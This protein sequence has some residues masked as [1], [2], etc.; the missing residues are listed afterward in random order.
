MNIAADTQRFLPQQTAAARRIFFGLEK[1]FVVFSIIYFTNG[2]IVR[3][4]L[5]AELGAVLGNL[6]LLIYFG[7]IVLF[8]VHQ[9]GKRLTLTV[10][11]GVLPFVVYIFASVMWSI[12]A[13]HSL[14]EAIAFLGITMFALYLTVRFRFETILNLLTISFALLAVGSLILGAVAPSLGI[15]QRSLHR[16]AWLGGFTHKNELGVSSAFGVL[17]FTLRARYAQTTFRSW[18]YWGAASLAFA[19][20]LLSTSS[21]SLVVSIASLTLVTLLYFLRGRRTLFVAFTL[22]AVVGATIGALVLV[23]NLQQAA[24][25]LGKDLTLTG[26]T[27]LWSE[28]IKDWEERPW[29]GYGMDAFWIETSPEANNMRY[30]LYWDIPHSHNGAIDLMLDL[31]VVGLVMGVGLY[32]YLLLSSLRFFQRSRSPL[33]VWPLLILLFILMINITETN[34]VKQKSLYWVLI[35]MLANFPFVQRLQGRIGV[36]FEE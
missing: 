36:Y 14:R 13:G 26:R 35:V 7:S 20:V 34:F 3:F 4:L 28:S 1:A 31:G 18:L 32:L 12:D 17:I 8:A 27:T 2:F 19:L 21:T 11:I 24:D 6:N 16:G 10:L 33:A 22:F 25:L 5:E 23:S 9:R 30:R 15:D 29:L